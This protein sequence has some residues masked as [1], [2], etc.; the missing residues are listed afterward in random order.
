MVSTHYH[1]VTMA[2]FS[3]VSVALGKL[4]SLNMIGI[5]KNYDQLVIIIIVL[6]YHTSILSLH[7]LAT[8]SQINC[9]ERMH[10][11]G[12]HL[13]FKSLLIGPFNDETRFIDR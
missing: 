9:C 1:L 8:Y 6:F 10:Y 11:Y 7:W 12:Q 4:A 5:N 2:E 13:C 3:M